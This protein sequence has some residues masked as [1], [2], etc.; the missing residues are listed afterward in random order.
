M[1]LPLLGIILCLLGCAI[2]HSLLG[3]RVL[4]GP[5]LQK[6]GNPVLEHGL[7]RIVLRGAWHLTSLM[8]VQMAAMVW[9][10]GADKTDFDAWFLWILGATYA[11]VAVWVLL[12]SRGRHPAWP[13]F[14]GIGGL[15][16]WIAMGG[17]T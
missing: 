16:L 10:L 5:L 15:A 9:A 4:I 13:L 14:A 3:E 8:W 11:A 1:S 12:V 6:R 7:S 2:L 17:G